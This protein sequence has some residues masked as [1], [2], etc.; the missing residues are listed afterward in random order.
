M[1][2]EEYQLLIQEPDP[3]TLLYN[4]NEG[5]TVNRDNFINRIKNIIKNEKKKINAFLLPK[6]KGKDLLKDKS[7][8]FYQEIYDYYR[9]KGFACIVLERISHL[10]TIAFVICFSVFLF[11]C[12]DYSL[13][14]ENSQLS[15]V[16][17]DQVY[18]IKKNIL[19][20][21]CKLKIPDRDI[22]L[23][24]WNAVI[25]KI[26]KL[27][28]EENQELEDQ[29]EIEELDAHKI[30]NIIM[31]K[32]NYFIALINKECI[33]FN[34]PFFES[35]QLLTDILAWNV[36]WCINNFV[37]DK[38]GHVKEYFLDKEKN[39][40]QRFRLMGIINIILLP[41]LL[42][43]TIVYT[44][45]RYSEEIYHHPGSIMKRT[46]NLLAQWKF[47][48][49]NELP[50]DFEKRL[51]RSYE[52]AMT[53]LNQF[54]NSRITIISKLIV[55]ISGSIVTVLTILTLIDQ[56]FFNSFEITPGGSVLFYIGIFTSILAFTKGMINEDTKEYDPQI[57]IENVAQETHYYPKK[58]REES[59]S[60]EVRNEFEGYFDKKIFIIFRNIY[61]LI[62]TPFILMITLPTLNLSSVGYVCSFAVFDFRKHGN[63]E[64]GYKIK[65]NDEI[66]DE[67]SEAEDKKENENENKSDNDNNKQSD[68][69]N[70]ENK[71]E[72]KYSNEGKME[73]SFLDFRAHYDSWIPKKET[74]GLEYSSYIN[75][76][77][78]KRYPMLTSQMMLNP[79]SI[80]G[81]EPEITS[82]YPI[83][84]AMYSSS[85]IFSVME[86]MIHNNNINSSRINYAI[87]N[88]IYN[89]KQNLTN[90]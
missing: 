69:N 32:E 14:S 77:K 27:Y 34:I 28:N 63:P 54:P 58:W 72:N 51:N 65:K 83:N 23:I 13:I 21:N 88:Q 1:S 86:D 33:K 3:S 39:L 36:Q 47:R 53:Y 81:K 16:I 50:H 20:Y 15:Q 35:K 46:Y 57:L 78:L 24:S 48:Q 74:G 90:N 52:S 22:Q 76:S 82:P 4:N 49:F 18:E 41:F 56:D 70:N 11:G 75:D 9:R 38:N 42:I 60:D 25:K 45:F 73:L 12:I 8:E 87:V 64:Y 85:L 2:K 84:S 30:V 71:K 37:Y 79:T 5:S 62:L 40:S 19:F 80:K 43:F 59:Y 89:E 31:R 44:F 17:V 66:I 55:F 29:S 6:P 67:D 26:I 10:V 68:E 61:G 7:D